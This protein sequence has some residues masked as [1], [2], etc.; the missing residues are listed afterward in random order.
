MPTNIEIIC[1]NTKLLKN[2]LYL[3]NQVEKRIKY[4]NDDLYKINKLSL[5]EK[6]F[7]HQYKLFTKE[8][9]DEIFDNCVKFIINEIIGVKNGK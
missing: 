3:P 2:N 1:E 9:L 8:E 7:K 6:L 5:K 4:L